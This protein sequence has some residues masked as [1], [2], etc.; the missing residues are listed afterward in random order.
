VTVDKAIEVLSK[1]VAS[2][3]V[4]ANPETVTAMKL[5]IEA[6]KFTKTSRDPHGNPEYNLLPGE[7][8]S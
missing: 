4:Q 3:F 1:R 8:R 6:L 7:T 5:A 2:P